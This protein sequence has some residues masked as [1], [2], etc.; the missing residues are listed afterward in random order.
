MPR[1][2][3]LEPS[4][5]P[6]P[7]TPY[8][9]AHPSFL[10]EWQDGRALLVDAG[11]D[12]AQAE[13][14]GRPIE[15][16]GGAPVV[17]HASIAERLAPA[18]AGRP[19]AI[20]FTHLHTDHVGGAVALCAALP[21]DTRVR[22]F[23]TGAQIDL[24]NFTTWPGRA[25][26]E[27]A[28]CLVRERLADAALAPLPDRPGAFAIRAAGHTP[29]SQIVG[30]FVRE[31]SGVRGYLFA[32]DVANAIDGVRHDVPKPLAYRLFLVPESESRQQRLRAFLREAEAAGFVIAI[33]HD[34]HHLAMTGIPVFGE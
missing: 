8:V 20:A 18:L 19:L 9:M 16:V 3:V 24:V 15:W 30:A 5:D 14:F 21:A 2:Q 6:A 11:M 4:L 17:P 12:R 22:W 32:G 34:E 13:A 26:L 33:A 25:E 10:L 31:A 7:E 23:Q 28:P 1:A 29:D 27:R